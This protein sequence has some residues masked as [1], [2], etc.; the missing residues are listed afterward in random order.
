MEEKKERDKRIDIIRALAMLGVIV[1]HI[2]VH[3]IILQLR[4]FDV[5][6]MALL[7]GTFFFLAALKN[8]FLIN[9]IFLRELKD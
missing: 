4:S 5:S 1:A 3:A 7:M 2:N 6:M 8:A 9:N